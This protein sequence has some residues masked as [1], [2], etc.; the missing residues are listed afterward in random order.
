[1]SCFLGRGEK[2]LRGISV[3]YT[4]R[5]VASG[6]RQ[7]GGSGH[8]ILCTHTAYTHTPPIHNHIVVIVN[9]IPF[10]TTIPDRHF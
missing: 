10:Q 7:V 3:R 5:M 9:I 6:W 1:M 2:A 4:I 8:D